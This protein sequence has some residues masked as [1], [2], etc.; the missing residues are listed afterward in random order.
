[1]FTKSVSTALV[2]AALAFSPVSKAS[3]DSGDFVAGALIG[4]VVGHAL[5]KEA[6]RKQAQKQTTRTT[7][8]YRSGIPRTQQGREIQ[9]SLNYF[10]FNAGGVDG[11]LGRQ[12]RAAIARYQAYMGYPATG[13]LTPLEEEILL[14]SHRRAQVGSFEVTQQMASHPDGP[15]G[16]LKNYRTELAGGTVA[17]APA[18]AALPNLGVA[19]APAGLP[20][21]Q[22]VPT[23]ASLAAHCNS[24]SL[25]TN[26]NGGYA[27]AAN[28]TDPNLV[29]NEQFCLART[30]AIE[31]GQRLAGQV[32][33]LSADQIA[34]QCAG[35]APTMATYISQLPTTPQN[36]VVAGVQA[37]AANSGMSLEQLR[38]TGQICLGVGYRTDNMEVAL[39]SALLLVGAGESAYAELVGHHLMRGFGVA[40]SQPLAAGWFDRGFA[41]VSGGVVPVFNPGEPGRTDLLRQAVARMN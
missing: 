33:G 14:T 36:Q 26:T 12:S 34:Q 28:M 15:R 7:T 40:P 17:P 8:V 16:L 20:N 11:Q 23:T 27:T 22:A 2:A 1:M 39:G 32:L 38:G 41:A 19:S 37:F 6:Q 35:L 30:Y 5:T 31:N 13:Q 4:G 21:F 25:V 24:V 3:A 9:S 10:G 18:N 29:L